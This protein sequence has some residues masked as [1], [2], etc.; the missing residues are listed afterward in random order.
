MNLFLK[1]DL[2]EILRNEKYTGNYIYNKIASTRPDGKFNRHEFKN[3]DE[4]IRI[5]GG[6]PQIISKE[7]FDKVP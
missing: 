4:V 7:D 2:Y 5:E 3:A 1:S 6:I